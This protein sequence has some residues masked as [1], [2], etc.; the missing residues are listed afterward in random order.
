MA[1]I[2]DFL[3]GIGLIVR[4]DSVPTQTFLPGIL[5]EH[6]TLV[7]DE[8]QLRYPGDLLHEAGHMAVAA[9]SRRRRFHGDVGKRAGDEMM[10]IAWS[11]AAALSI[12][13]D[14]AV[15]FHADGYRGGSAAILENFGQGHY[16]GVPLLQWIGLTAEPRQ[17]AELGIPP[18]PHMRKWVRDI[19]DPAAAAATANEPA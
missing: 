2:A 11:Y 10:A 15:V 4:A 16:I 6:G 9:P 7:V 18:Y 13:L 14:P 8:A 5:V 1:Q 3:L 17:A 12:G 19:E